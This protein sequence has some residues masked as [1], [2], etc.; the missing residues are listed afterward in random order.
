MLLLF[1]MSLGAAFVQ[2]VSGFGFGIFIMTV[3]PYIMPSYGEATTLSGLMAM[4]T[5]LIIAIRNYRYLHWKKLFIILFTFLIVSYI[6]VQ[7]VSIASD[8]ILKK[9]LGGILIFA[10]IWFLFLSKRVHLPATVPVQISM[11][12][13]SG[14]MGGF[15]GM[16]GPPAVLY[17]ISSA[18]QKEE[19]MAM[20]QMYFL[21]G[22]IFMTG[23]RAQCG[24][25]TAAVLH[26]WCCGIVAVLIGTTLGSIVFR[27]V[28]LDILRKIIYA[29]MAI[30]GIIALL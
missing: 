24:Y 20:A 14:L 17:F 1:L 9:L 7:F 23:Y 11:G 15:F 26:G 4:V 19:Y 8:G 18:K 6:A 2:R 5:S 27:F 10:S 12:T 21:L 3:L 25:L 28:S 16:Q 30:S 29:Y 13:I 22:N